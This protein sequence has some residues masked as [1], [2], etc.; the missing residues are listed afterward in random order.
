[1]RKMIFDQIKLFLGIYNQLHP[2]II[3]VSQATN[4]VIADIKPINR[5]I[6]IDNITMEWSKELMTLYSSVNLT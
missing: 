5:N 2:Y 3:F 1:M 6:H 4:M